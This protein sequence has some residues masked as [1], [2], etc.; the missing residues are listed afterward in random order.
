[1]DQGIDREVTEKI[2]LDPGI[3]FRSFQFEPGTI[4]VK[5]MQIEGE[6]T[7]TQTQAADPDIINISEIG[8][9]QGGTGNQ[10]K[11]RNKIQKM[12]EGRSLA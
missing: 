2:V 11:E 5:I 6:G 1:M 8:F 4:G 10:K 3:S 7:R 12:G 9:L